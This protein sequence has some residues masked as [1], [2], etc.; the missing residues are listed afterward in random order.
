M[1][2]EFADLLRGRRVAVAESCTGGLVCQTLAAAPGSMD[3]FA[4]GVVAYQRRAK[5]SLLHVP[6][7]PLVSAEVAGQM[8][9]GAAGLFDTE[10]GVSV[11]GSAGPDPLDGAEVGTVVIGLSL[12]GTTTCVRYFFDGTPT[13]IC[14]QARDA[15][16]ECL[17]RALGAR[18]VEA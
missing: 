8:A 2:D 3:W 6:R 5:E 15:A 10:I 17:E 11:T 13:E 12:D 4:G 16:I 1:R 14:A 18:A 9:T 7:A